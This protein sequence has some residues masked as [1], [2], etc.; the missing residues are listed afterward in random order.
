[1]SKKWAKL[2]KVGIPLL[3]VLSWLLF[4]SFYT[5]PLSS[6]AV[7]TTFGRVTSTQEAGLHFKFPVPI[8]Q[9]RI[10]D[11]HKTRKMELG[12]REV[13][14][15]EYQSVADESM[16][17]TNDLNFVNVDFFVEY[18]VS[19]AEKFLYRSE[20]PELML[21]NLVQGVARS[22]VGSMSV[23]DVLTTGKNKLQMDVKE[24]VNAQ[25]EMMDIGIAILDIKVNDVEPPTEEVTAAFRAVETA[26][27]QKD[28]M[29]N[30]ALQYRNKTIPEANAEADKLSRQAEAYKVQMEQRGLGEVAR[31][32]EMLKQYLNT[33]DV[34][35]QRMYWEALEEVLP[36]IKVYIDTAGDDISK[37]MPLEPFQ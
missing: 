25:M 12:Y 34:T 36:G 27:Q 23:D 28:S 20:D 33:P 32:N 13:G 35:R 16:M 5:V 18:K 9:V 37:I 17:I 4:T 7:V 8:Q 22:I 15:G 1:M 31:F 21:R 24:A 14:N 2:L 6:Q 10:V 30:E 29:I 26:K 19:N 3:L 11:I